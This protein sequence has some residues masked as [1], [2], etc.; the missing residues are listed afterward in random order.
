VRKL[1]LLRWNLKKR[2]LFPWWWPFRRKYIFPLRARYRHWYW[3]RFDFPALLLEEQIRSAE[4]DLIRRYYTNLML[5][6]LVDWAEAREAKDWTKADAIRDS[7]ISE[8]WRVRAKK[9]GG[10]VINWPTSLPFTD[11][12]LLLLEK[13]QQDIS[14]FQWKRGNGPWFFPKPK[15]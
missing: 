3:D 14:P 4:Y 12:E 6:R 15:P 2:F 10:Y 9:D 13:F 7:M 1:W 5:P 8:G 11:A